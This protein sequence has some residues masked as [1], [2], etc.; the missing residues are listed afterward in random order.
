MIMSKKT[1]LWL[2]GLSALVFLGANWNFFLRHREEISGS[3][4]EGSEVSSI[5]KM[6]DEKAKLQGIVT[7]RCGRGTLKMSVPSRGKVILHP[8]KLAHILPKVPGVAKE[9]RKN[10]G[11]AV[12]QG[13]VLAVIESREIADAKAGYLAALEKE[14]WASSLFEREKELH[15][16]RVSSEEEFLN[17]KFAFEEAKIN[18]QLAKQKLFAFGVSEGEISQMVDQNEVDFRLYEI[19][20]P[21]SGVVIGRHITQGEYV[22][23]KS[24]IYEIADLSRVWVEIGIYPKDLEKVKEGQLVEIAHPNQAR[25]IKGKIIYLSPLIEEE[26]I[27]AKAIAELD[28]AKGEWRP[29][30]FVKAHIVTDYVSAPLVVA[31]SAIQTID[32]EA[33]IFI[34]IAEGFQKTPVQIGQSDEECVEVIGGIEAGASYASTKAFLL[35]AD[36]GK[37]SVEH[38]D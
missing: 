11:D 18:L 28:N 34:Q 14:K 19:K 5:V 12:L 2:L 22:E 23:D 24:L 7:R 38:G 32:G 33:V 31:K 20:A 21:I 6:D 10:I 27:V 8:D 37:D 16:K 25:S 29:G 35:K 4:E 1:R 9:A 36:L 30:T 17:S 26:T 15:G 13:E 3:T